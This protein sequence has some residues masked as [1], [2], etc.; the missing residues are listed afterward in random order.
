[1]RNPYRALSILVVLGSVLFLAASWNIW[2][3]EAP[4]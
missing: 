3:A 4:K 1:M 2:N